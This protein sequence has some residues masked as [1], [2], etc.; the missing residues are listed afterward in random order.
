MKSTSTEISRGVRMM[1]RREF[2]SVCAGFLAGA[3]AGKTSVFS[4]T[5][6]PE[7]D[8]LKG[9][10]FIDA[11]SHPDEFWSTRSATDF[12]ASFASIK[13]SGM[14]ASL[15]CAVG[16][17]KESERFLGR[18]FSGSYDTTGKGDEVC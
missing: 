8:L 18:I 16:D 10:T 14:S 17:S 5:A 7:A 1:K 4:A 12:S 6:Q 2:L 3:L 13:K 9:I 11:H 15:F